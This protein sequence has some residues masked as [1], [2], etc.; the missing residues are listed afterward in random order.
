R[1]FNEQGAVPTNTTQRNVLRHE[2]ENDWH[3]GELIRLLADLAGLLH[4]LGK[5]IEAFQMRLKAALVGRNLIRHEWVS[6]RLFEA[7]VGNDDDASW[8]A[9]LA[10]SSSDMRRE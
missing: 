4:D 1:R 2:D 3:T 8:L 9:R 6:L 5:A 10:T 7:F